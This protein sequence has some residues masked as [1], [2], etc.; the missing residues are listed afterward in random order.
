MKQK[1]Y[2]YHL[3][4]PAGNWVAAVERVNKSSSLNYLY[5][6]EPADIHLIAYQTPLPAWP[7]GR[8]FGAEAE[9]RWSRRRDGQVN[10]VLLAEKPF[11]NEDDWQP[12]D[13]WAEFSDGEELAGDEFA[14]EER[15]MML[16]GTS[17]RHGD[18]NASPAWTD[19]RIF[20]PVV[21]PLADDQSLERWARLTI[22]IYRVNGYP[23]L[24]RMVDMEGSSDDTKI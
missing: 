7:D 9:V 16:R 5:A 10:L 3:R 6:E 14:V 22:K 13:W 15:R 8:A 11:S 23:L 17:R 19:S 1:P 4:L 24:T 12:C 21:Y 18:P 2:L 20:G